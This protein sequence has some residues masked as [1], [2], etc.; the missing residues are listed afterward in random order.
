M[1]EPKSVSLDWAGRKLTLETGKVARQADGAVFAT[2]G[3]TADTPNQS[4]ID[5]RSANESRTSSRQR[6]GSGGSMER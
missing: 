5:S 4:A 1:F 2:W 3:E 6:R